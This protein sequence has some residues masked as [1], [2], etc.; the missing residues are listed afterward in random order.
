MTVSGFTIT[1]ADRQRREPV[2]KQPVRDSQ[3]EPAISVGSLKDYELTA[4][5]ENPSLERSPPPKACPNR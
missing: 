1:G 5:S 2:P 4:K 3:P